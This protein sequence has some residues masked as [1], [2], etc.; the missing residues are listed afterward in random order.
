MSLIEVMVEGGRRVDSRY[1]SLGGGGAPVARG[2]FLRRAKGTGRD[3]SEA[4]ALPE[5]DSGPLAWCSAL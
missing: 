2:A 1:S 5:P 4:E 3:E